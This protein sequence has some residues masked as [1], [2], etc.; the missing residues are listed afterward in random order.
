M[1]QN[2]ELGNEYICFYG[3]LIYDQGGKNIQWKNPLQ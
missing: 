1:E 3:Q 2:R